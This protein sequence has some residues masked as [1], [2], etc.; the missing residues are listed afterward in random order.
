MVDGCGQRIV[1]HH[2]VHPF[3]RAVVGADGFRHTPM[4][5]PQHALDCHHH[6]AGAAVVDLE[7]VIARAREQRGVVDEPPGVGAVVAVDGLVIVAHAERAEPGCAEQ[8]NEQNVGWCEVLELVDEQYPAGPLGSRPGSGVD[9]Q[10][11]DGRQDLRVEIDRARTLH[12]G[13]DLLHDLFEATHIAVVAGLD[14]VVGE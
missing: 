8:A 13:I 7:G 6:I 4:V 2:T 14:V 9:E 11:G 12:R 1:D 10:Q 5:A 3:G